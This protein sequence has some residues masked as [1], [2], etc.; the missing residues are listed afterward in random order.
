MR[1][2]LNS[3][4]FVA[5]AAL[6][7]LVAVPA[8]AD[9]SSTILRIEATNSMGTGVFEVDV[10]D[11]WFDEETETWGWSGAGVDIMDGAD[12]LATFQSVTLTLQQDPVIFLNFQGT[13]A[14]VPTQITLTTALLS[15]P[16][17]NNASATT[18]AG[19]TLTDSNA[20]GTAS[21]D[22]NS[23]TGNDFAFVT[24]YNGMVPGG[25]LFR[26][27]IDE[28]NVASIAGSNSDTYNSGMVPIGAVSDMS[29]QVSFLLSASDSASGTSVFA[30]VPEPASFAL[31]ALGALALRRRA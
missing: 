22:G 2:F 21:L 3:V 19:L 13:A 11:A 28:I 23:G 1:S 31:L 4:G 15:F 14:N 12:V 16:T 24:N 9:V 7:G 25:T 27:A 29:L 26:E 30:V 20:S 5:C 6:A 10:D 17:I 8:S 18:S